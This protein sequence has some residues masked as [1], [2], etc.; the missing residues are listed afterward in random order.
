MWQSRIRDL[1]RDLS[2]SN[3]FEGTDSFVRLL[4]DDLIS[5]TS[6]SQQ[7]QY[8]DLECQSVH[9]S[10]IDPELQADISKVREN[11]KLFLHH[12]CQ[13]SRKVEVVVY[14]ILKIFLNHEIE[15][16]VSVSIK[17]L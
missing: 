6:N 7:V 11:V 4:V 13:C 15:K 16:M 1:H 2:Q 14:E 3:F 9:T 12:Y 17:L 8:L 5:N 10:S